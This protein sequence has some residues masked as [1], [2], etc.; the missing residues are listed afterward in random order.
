MI[1]SLLA[2]AIANVAI[3][4]TRTGKVPT[5]KCTVAFMKNIL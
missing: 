2:C 4:S 3:G 1:G 5:E